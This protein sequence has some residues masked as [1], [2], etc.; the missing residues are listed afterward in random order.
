MILLFAALIQGIVGT[1]LYDFNVK[2]IYEKDQDLAQYRGN[3][4]IVVNVASYWG[5]TDNHYKQ[6][7]QLYSKYHE[8]GFE[9]LAFPCNQF[10]NQEPKSNSEILKFVQKYNVTF[11]MFDKIK[12]NAEE[13]N[14]VITEEEPL[15]EWLKSVLPCGW[16]DK[17]L[18]PRGDKIQWNFTKFLINRNGCPVK[19]F[20]PKEDPLTM[21]NDVENL[22]DESYNSAQCPEDPGQCSNGNN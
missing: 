2:D 13:E 20:E 12:V 22:L 3:V 6:L 11:P 1:T 17:K 5:L 16:L 10:K 9:V 8:R 15:F 21:E 19:R 4:T 7:Q 18:V 14:G